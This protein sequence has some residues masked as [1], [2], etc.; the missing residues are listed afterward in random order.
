MINS[1]PLLGRA[2]KLNLNYAL[3]LTPWAPA[4]T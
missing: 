3:R 4:E 1:R 2:V